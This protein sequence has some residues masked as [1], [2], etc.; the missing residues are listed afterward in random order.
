M[1]S[2]MGRRNAVVLLA[3]LLGIVMIACAVVLTP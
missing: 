2:S 3:M 1:F